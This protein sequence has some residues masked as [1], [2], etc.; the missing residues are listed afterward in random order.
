LL[1]YFRDKINTPVLAVAISSFSAFVN[2]YTT[3]SLLPL[4]SQIF[5][6][7]KAEVSL[8]VSATAIAVS[9]AAPLVGLLADVAGRKNV[10]VLAIL[11]L[12]I[13]T[14]LAATAY[15]LNTL[16]FWRF[17]QGFFIAIIF[18][19]TIAYISEEWSE[20]GIGIVMTAYITGGNIVGGVL[21]RFLSGL[22]A[23]Y[24]G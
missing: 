19:V 16:I 8:T 15:D 1:K 17:V 3:Q 18:S 2:L 24:F 6:A 10:I 23:S 13:P 14:F 9:L 22:V 12:T 7:S 5:H 21:G 20:G 11:G 4:F